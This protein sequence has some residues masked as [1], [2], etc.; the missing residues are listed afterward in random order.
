MCMLL[1]LLVEIMVE[2]GCAANHIK[3]RKKLLYKK[4]PSRYMPFGDF[5][6]RG[7]GS[8]TG[9][10]NGFKR[11]KIAI[12]AFQIFLLFSDILRFH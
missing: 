12:V 1:L 7:A 10:L 11:V 6:A 3:K 9:K 5:S 4:K 2:V 8:M